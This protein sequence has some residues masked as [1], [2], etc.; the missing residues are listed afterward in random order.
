VL[1]GP[2]KLVGAHPPKKVRDYDADHSNIQTYLYEHTTTV[3]RATYREIVKGPYAVRQIA[4]SHRPRMVLMR[5]LLAS[6]AESTIMI[7]HETIK[8]N[9]PD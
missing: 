2:Q 9:P 5:R 6:C 4:Y 3:R 7:L 1:R 8:P